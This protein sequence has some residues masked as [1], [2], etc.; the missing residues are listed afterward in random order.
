MIEG[1]QLR[2]FRAFL[3]E[4][5]IRRRQRWMRNW[6]DRSLLSTM[7]DERGII[8]AYIRVFSNRDRSS[9]RE[10]RVRKL[11]AAP[12]ERVAFQRLISFFTGLPNDADAMR[13]VCRLFSDDYQ[14]SIAWDLVSEAVPTLVGAAA[15]AYDQMRQ[16][17]LS[18][19]RDPRPPFV[20]ELEKKNRRMLLK[21]VPRPRCTS[22]FCP[23][24]IIRSVR[25]EMTLS[26][27]YCRPS[28]MRRPRLMGYAEV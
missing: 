7:P 3:P 4:H 5:W 9:P 8:D 15:L 20:Q 13:A 6:R 18:A 27:L 1:Q 2:Q 21:A 12:H 22:R 19:L 28:L 16:S 10:G 23:P 17:P 26:T 14:M 11:L 24:V 25:N